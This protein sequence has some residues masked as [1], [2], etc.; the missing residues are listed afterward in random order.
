MTVDTVQPR[1]YSPLLS[2][3]MVVAVF[4]G[5]QFAGTALFVAGLMTSSSFRGLSSD[6]L[7]DKIT[8]NHWLYLALIVVLEALI[9]GLIVGLMRKRSISV[10]NVGFNS[11]RLAYLWYAVAGYVVVFLLNVVILAIVKHLAPGLNLD[12]KQDLGVSGSIQGQALVPIFFAL[13]LIPPF[14]EEFIMRGFLFT[15]LRAR[16]SF[17]GSAV[18]VSLL[19]GLA[20][21][22]E[23]QD[24]LFW[25][26]AISFFTLSLVLCYLRE[27]T[28]SLWPSIGVHM[29]QNGLAFM[30]LYIWKVA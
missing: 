2:I 14:V 30:A 7:Q 27:K 12:Q 25:T 19:F 1:Y 17:W 6:Q 22:T 4:F 16:L 13:V 26:G 10:K 9:V 23:G 20:H 18:I 15:N 3:V 5:A 29:L 8:S 11:P 24:G 28:Q 21:I